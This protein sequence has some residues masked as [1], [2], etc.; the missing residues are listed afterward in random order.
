MAN[1]YSTQIFWDAEDQGYVARSTEFPGL[2]AAGESK[3]EAVE[4]L[5][6]AIEMVLDM[7]V[8]SGLPVP[9]PILFAECDGDAEDAPPPATVCDECGAPMDWKQGCICKKIRGVW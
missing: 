7:V 9:E 2:L 8:E 1:K 5:E 4:H 3:A 6:D